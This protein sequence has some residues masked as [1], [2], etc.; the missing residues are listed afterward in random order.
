MEEGV[1]GL[2]RDKPCLAGRTLL[3]AALINQVLTKAAT[4]SLTD[5]VHWHAQAMV[6][7]LASARGLEARSTAAHRLI[8]TCI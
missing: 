6:K 5:A 7:W 1:A 2:L 8:L 3:A 4:E